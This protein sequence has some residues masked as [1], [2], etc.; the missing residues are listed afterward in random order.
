MCYVG[1]RWQ[2]LK[3]NFQRGGLATNSMARSSM[4]VARREKA[5]RR[6]ARG[7]YGMAKRCLMLRK[8]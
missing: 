1:K 6:D 7:V 8:A 4:T 3:K 5:S 2:H